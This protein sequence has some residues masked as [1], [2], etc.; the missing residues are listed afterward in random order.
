VAPARDSLSAAPS[1]GSVVRAFFAAITR[2]DWPDVWRLGARNVGSGPSATYNGMVSGY[3][4]TARDVVTSLS[5]TGDSVSVRIRAYETTGAAQDYSFRY[6]VRNEVIV[7][8]H[9]LS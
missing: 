2:H 9:P 8:G 6:V 7:S 5:V 1:P 4:L 3:R